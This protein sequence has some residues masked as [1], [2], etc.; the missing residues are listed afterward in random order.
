MHLPGYPP[1]Y[2]GWKFYNPVTRKIVISERAEFDEHYF[3]ALKQKVSLPVLPVVG[4]PPL[5]PVLDSELEEVVDLGGG[6]ELK[7]SKPT[8]PRVQEIPDKDDPNSKPPPSSPSPS[9]PPS[10]YSPSPP[11]QPPPRKCQKT[12]HIPPTLAS[13]QPK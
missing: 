6:L 2:A 5:D 11:P 12:K 8:Q 10:N 3:P 7:C 4:S 13:N 1:D 9:P